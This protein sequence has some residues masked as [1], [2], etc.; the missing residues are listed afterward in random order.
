MHVAYDWV[1]VS[2]RPIMDS[3][4][5]NTTPD[6]SYRLPS[7]HPAAEAR[8]GSSIASRDEIDKADPPLP[9]TQAQGSQLATEVKRRQEALMVAYLI[10]RLGR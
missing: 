6:A 3:Y 10:R 1:V 9:P 4:E 8:R 5:R 2:C 7:R